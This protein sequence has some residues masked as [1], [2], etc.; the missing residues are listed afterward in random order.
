LVVHGGNGRFPGLIARRLGLTADAVWSTTAETGN[1][2][3][4]SLPVA[5]ALRSER[6]SGPVLWAAVAPGLQWAA[7]LSGPAEGVS[8]I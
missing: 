7:A 2:G 1:V 8:H 5:W 4:A 6:A 3:A